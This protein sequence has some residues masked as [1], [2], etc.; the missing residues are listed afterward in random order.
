MSAF[1]P[2]IAETADENTF[3]KDMKNHSTVKL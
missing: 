2:F 3:Y 1:S